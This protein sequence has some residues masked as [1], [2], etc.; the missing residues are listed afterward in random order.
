M[1][2]VAGHVEKEK[3]KSLVATLLH[4]VLL[5]YADTSVTLEIPYKVDGP[6]SPANYCCWSIEPSNLEYVDPCPI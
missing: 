6:S 1:H 4:L 2:R 5:L 3:K